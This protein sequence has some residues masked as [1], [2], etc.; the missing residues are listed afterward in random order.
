MTPPSN[1]P[2]CGVCATKLVKNGKTSAGRTRWR[3]KNCGASAT[4]A[5][6]DVTAKAQLKEFIGWLLGKDSQRSADGGTG[7]SFRA[8]TGWCWQIEV[9]QPAPTGEV[10]RQI[11]VDGTYFQD[12]CVLIAFDGTHV[13]GWQ[14][15]DHEKKIAWAQ[16]L[17]RFPAPDV[18]VTDGGRGLRSAMDQHWP[19]TRIQRCYFHILAAVRKHTT[20]NPRLEAGQEILGL[21]R[22]LMRV[23][24]L[25]AAAAW[26]GSY[27]SWEA[28]WEALLK[29]RTFYRPG[30]DRPRG[31]G[32]H[33]TWWYTHRSLRSVRA[34][35]RQLIA[36]DS[37]FTFLAADLNDE[38][39]PPVARTTSPLEGW[40]N[41]AI[42]DLLRHHKGLT[43]DHARTAVDW[44]L[45]TLTEHPLD[46]WELAEQH[47]RRAKDSTP[48]KPVTEEPLGPEAYGTG[49]TA[50]DGLWSRKGWAGRG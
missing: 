47:R 40:P 49:I 33:R 5:R 41:R 42:K 11:I 26:M 8:R 28:Q 2:L 46:P 24:D 50:E 45:N 43:G 18:V 4:R 39:S 6:T 16:L 27:A 19:Q 36:D 37:L 29:Q 22:Q 25:D 23:K 34:L 20:L 1:Q 7:R 15:C 9:P 3:C 32:R 35:Y 10:H 14:W 31:V 48:Q 30:T 44:L 38:H 12:W 17:K 13:L 21:T